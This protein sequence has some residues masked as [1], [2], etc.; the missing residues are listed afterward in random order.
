MDTKEIKIRFFEAA[1]AKLIRKKKEADERYRQE[2]SPA[3]VAA[4]IGG[5]FVSDALCE[6]AELDER[7]REAREILAKLKE[8]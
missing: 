2:G 5:V 1:I 7:I 3:P 8:A 4:L 6:S